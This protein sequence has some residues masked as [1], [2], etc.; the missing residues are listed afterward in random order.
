MAEETHRLSLDAMARSQVCV[1]SRG[2]LAGEGT[3]PPTGE[4]GGQFQQL[5]DGQ[6]AAP[7]GRGGGREDQPYHTARGF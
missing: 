3:P 6:S 1:G 7:E 2:F 4:E 5:A